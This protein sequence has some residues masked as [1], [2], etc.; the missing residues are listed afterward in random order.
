MR[1]VNKQKAVRAHRGRIPSPGRPTVAWRE[2]RVKFW[3]AIAAG[4]KTED[5]VVAAGVSSPVGFR[6][7]RHAGGVNPRLPQPVSG[8]YLSFREREEIA[9]LIPR[10]LGVRAT[11]CEVG[12]DP[13]TIWR[14]LRRNASARTASLDYRASLAQCHAK[15]RAR[16]P[17]VAKLVVNERL[18]GYL[19]DTLAGVVRD[20]SGQLSDPLVRNV[21][22]GTNRTAR[23]GD[24]CGAGVRSRSRSDFGSISPMMRAFG[25]ATKRST[26]GSTCRAGVRSSVSWSPV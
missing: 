10:G 18:R 7:L 15:R 5:A 26:R 3:A 2:D 14:K 13:S 12:R 25:S 20:A 24:G 9:L 22:A 16:R 8:R 6:W 17:K 4:A 23:I 19:Q 11:S 1:S 21:R